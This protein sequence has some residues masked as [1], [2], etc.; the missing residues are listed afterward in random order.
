MKKNLDTAFW[1]AIKEQDFAVP[2][3]YSV[4]SLTA[5]LLQALGDT[6]P[7][8]R[9]GP[10]HEVF[11]VWIHRGVYAPDA[12]RALANQMLQNLEVGLGEAETDTVFLRAFSLLILTEILQEDHERPFLSEAELRGFMERGLA[13]LEREQDVRGYVPGKGWAHAVAHAA[14]FLMVLARHRSLHAADLERLLQA[15]ARKLIGPPVIIYLY[16]EDERLAYAVLTAL[17]RNLLPM[18]VLA[19]WIDGLARPEGAPWP[20]STFYTPEQTLRYHNLKTFLRSL[21]FQLRLASPSPQDG[22]LLLATLEE[23][24]RAMDRGYYVLP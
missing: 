19:R 8:V 10:N 16:E 4:E 13:Y 2:A 5:F 11:E 15:C 3:G 6:N 12:L 14:D 24:V 22:P 7:A 18:S 23:A 17:R 1:Q 20:I 21:Y 9:E